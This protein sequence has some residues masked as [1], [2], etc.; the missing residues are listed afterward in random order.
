MG[1]P[2]TATTELPLL[3][4]T[5][6][7]SAT[8]TQCSQE[9]INKIT[10]KKEKGYDKRG[11]EHNSRCHGLRYGMAK[12][13]ILKSQV[14]AFPKATVTFIRRGPSSLVAWNSLLI[15]SNPVPGKQRRGP[16]APFTPH[17]QH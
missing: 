3:F 5:R 6:E 8:K 15:T 13:V 2:R 1:S 10:Y 16:T 4:A 9:E 11:K 12:E 7:K 17:L 14:H